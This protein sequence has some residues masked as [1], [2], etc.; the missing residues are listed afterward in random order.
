MKEINLTVYL[1]DTEPTGDIMD[2]IEIMCTKCNITNKIISLHQWPESK[3]ES[4]EA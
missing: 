3:H 1:E 2:A 4:R